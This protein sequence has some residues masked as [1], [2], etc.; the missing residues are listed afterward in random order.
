MPPGQPVEGFNSAMERSSQRNISGAA[1]KVSGALFSRQPAVHQALILLLGLLIYSNTFHVPFIFD[2]NTIIVNNPRLQDLGQFMRSFDLRESRFVGYLTFALNYAV[3][4]TN[5]AGYHVV[6]LII[7]IAASLLVYWLIVSILQTPAISTPGGAL[8]QSVSARHGFALSIALLF[9]SHPVQT[10]AVTYI[11]Q[12]LTSLATLFYVLACLLFVRW[13]LSHEGADSSVSSRSFMN[14]A[15]YGGSLAAAFLA[16]RTKEISITLPAM[17]IICESMFFSGNAKRRIVPLLPYLVLGVIIIATEIA[18]RGSLGAVAAIDP[19]AGLYQGLHHLSRLEYLFTQFRVIATYLRLL[20]L[21][22]NQNLDYDYPVS[23]TLFDSSVIGALLFLLAV[24]AFAAYAYRRFR[25]T[26]GGNKAAYGLIAF[27]LFWFFVT[28]SVESSIIPID[29]VIM[30]HR[31]YLPSVGFFVAFVALGTLLI[32]APGRTGEVVRK[33]GPVMF[34]LVVIALSISAYARN[35]TWSDLV[36][37]HEDIVGKSPRKPRAHINLG[38][39]YEERGLLDSAAREYSTALLLNPNDALARHNLGNLFY[40]HGY[41]DKALVHYQAIVATN[42]NAPSTH[43]RIGIIYYRTG[44]YQEA[45][46]AFQAALRLRPDLVQSRY[47]LDLITK[48]P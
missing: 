6:N 36:S 1:Q 48:K 7:H 27:G 34:A 13:R 9:V 10:Q 47:Y 3:N 5:V 8:L 32:G 19:V 18:T 12:R 39:S 14:I 2:D 31:V 37:I 33:T 11:V 21:P 45:K 44:R 15:L 4:G 26:A 29:D 41:W 46:E 22:V 42:W 35:A 43:E 24:V 20:V 23:T 40:K 17:L 30:E 28:L 25:S 38:V 16:F